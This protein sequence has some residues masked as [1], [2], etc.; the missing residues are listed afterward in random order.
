MKLHTA[1]L[2]L[3][4]GSVLAADAPKKEAAIKK[5]LEAI[6]GK[7]IIASADR[8]GKPD[9]NFKDAQVTIKGNQ[10][11]RKFKGGMAQATFTL[12]PTAKLKAI[13]AAYTEG[14]DKGK[15]LQGIYA[16]E[17]ETWK[18]C[19]AAAG[20]PRPTEFSSK[21][22]SG[23]LLLVFK[24]PP[25][26]PPPPIFV[27]KKLEAAVREALHETKPYL[28][29]G[30]LN[31][32]SVLEAS[33]K[34]ITN[35][36]GLD[37]CKNVALINLAKNQ[38]ADVSPLKGLTTLQSLDLSSNKIADITP[39]GGLTKL[40][41]LELSNN[42]ISKIDAVAGLSGSLTSLYLSGNKVNDIKPIGK[43]TRLWYLSLGGNQIKDIGPLAGVT[44][45]GVLELKDNQVTD[46]TPL[47]KQ[48]ELHI[49]ML[50]RNKITD[51]AP[52]LN[53]LKADA[54]KEKRFAPYLEIYIQG[55]PLSDAA[56]SK[57]LPA[58]KGIV[59]KIES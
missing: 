42:Q 48:T 33:D 20:K 9:P 57:Q 13:D 28:T 52:L 11:T 40:Q 46:I 19:Y 5:E 16:I 29:E 7:W 59:R 54:E 32:L 47:A 2:L 24:R 3:F 12:D 21:P 18:L 35:L 41:R 34:G 30:D 6:Q 17:K 23:Q 51:L 56:K 1:W 38:I 14:P 15:T 10:A 43:L 25:T 26:P 58:I 39:L 44:K 55:N 53:S 36:T 45:I 37:K 31:N 27:D 8:D 4:A 50:E 22:G 49:L